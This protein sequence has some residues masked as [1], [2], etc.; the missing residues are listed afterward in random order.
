MKKKSIKI[1]LLITGI[2]VIFLL[3]LPGI[4]K[5][6]AINNSK[7][8]LGRQIQI[9]KLKYNY[10][11]STIKIFDFKMLE[12]NEQ[13]NFIAFD[14]LIVNIEPLALIKDKI[15]IEA[16]YLKGLDVKVIM[17]DST[18]NFDDLID[19]HTKEEDSILNDTEV[20]TSFK[21]SLSN[22]ES[23]DANFFF[24]NKDVN[25]V[26]H[27]EDL[28]FLIPFIGWD[29]AEKSNV[30]IKF[31]FKEGGYIESKLNIQP[32]NGDYDATIIISDLYL[33]SFYKYV[34]EYA[35]INSLKGSVNSK[36]F[37]KGNTNEVRNSV[38]SGKV[39]VNDFNI[40]DTNNESFLT[41]KKAVFI[42]KEI[43]VT[44]GS[45]VLDSL[46]IY[47]P[48]VSFKIDSISNNLSKIFLLKEKINATNQEVNTI[49]ESD[50]IDITPL[51]YAIN[52]FK[53][54]NGT[55]DYSDSLMGSPTNYNFSNIKLNADS[56]ST[57]NKWGTIQSEM[58]INDDGFLNIE[59]DFHPINKNF[60]VTFSSQKLSL[61]PF[62]KYSVEYANIN[63]IEGQFNTQ[64]SINGTIN[65]FENVLISGLIEVSNLSM[66]D[67]QNKKF[68]SS[69]SISC[70][71]EEINVANSSYRIDNLKITEPYLYF[72]MDSITNNLSKIFYLE[73]GSTTNNNSEI[74]KNP[75]LFYAINQL[76]V[77]NG[78]LDYTDNLTGNPFNYHLSDI[79]IDADKILSDADWVKINSDMLLN[80]RGTLNAAIGFNPSTLNDADIDI[81]IE[82]FLLSDIN[83]YTKHYTGH[84]IIEGDMYYYSNSK[85]TSGDIVSENRLLVKSA[86]LNTTN[87]GLYKL[88]LKFALF[89]LKDKNGDINLEIPVRGDLN[90]PK[91]SIGKI[92]WNTFK[93]LIVKTVASPVN[94]LAGLVDGDPKE[95]EVI[96]FSYL[97]SIPTEKQ[98]KQLDKIL[99]LEQKKSGLKI[100]MNYFVDRNFQ[101][102]AI[103]KQE[104]GTQYFEYTQKDYLKDEKG[105]ETYL[106]NKIENDSISV[107]KAAVIIIGDEQLNELVLNLNNNLISKIRDYIKVSQ[108]SSL[109][110][111]NIIDP[112]DIKNKG[113]EPVLKIEY[114]L[115]ENNLPQ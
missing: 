74:S 78:V 54:Y 103:A 76:N 56:I 113:L 68:I 73:D 104:I 11:T 62:Y 25:D 105:F 45:Y 6:Y 69:K 64:L 95:M 93:N 34:A 37:I 108:D 36:F 23:K 16:F 15:E 35:T 55:I 72:E 21:Y 51:H 71:L 32:V 88:P 60:N 107:G 33:D 46:N 12:Q 3:F 2:I 27:L 41:A 86:T 31:N 97:D 114:G 1:L 17:K 75:P 91:V 100:E 42:L 47:E 83:I 29:Q 102:E 99:E 53:I 57:N 84:N 20:E 85:I 87:E 80:N 8:L 13:D 67:N 92:V 106:L 94:F 101:K 44:N 61:E 111:V 4:L 9:E 40:T 24:D 30:D 115:Q 28:S 50:S 18:F 59:L 70:N 19:F 109:I 79:K 65:K 96:K 52:H 14:T 5:R 90:D 98:Y 22:L 43:D 82:N 10:F 77:I 58:T 112:K 110:Q 39:E 38:V 48:F 66:T 89:L 26:T 81:V 63:S 49:E 7:E